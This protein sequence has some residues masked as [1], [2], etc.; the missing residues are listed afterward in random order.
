MLKTQ[1][2]DSQALNALTQKANLETQAQINKLSDFATTAQLQ[3]QRAS[4]DR[5][6]AK[7]EAH[8][9]A[10]ERDVFLF[11]I[12]ALITIY[13]LTYL[14]G[15]IASFPNQL[16]EIALWLGALGTTFGLSYV[17]CRFVVALFARMIP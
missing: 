12:C 5:D 13:V 11:T 17:A 3:Y 16:V 4:I 15:I 7:L 9:N 14:R 1:L 10:K 2:T 6:K 8:E